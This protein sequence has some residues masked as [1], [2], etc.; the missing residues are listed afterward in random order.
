[1]PSMA[2]LVGGETGAK[3]MAHYVRS[4]S[5]LQHDA[6][7]AGRAKP[8]FAT[9]AACHGPEARGNPALGAPNLTDDV[10]LHGSSEAAIVHTILKGRASV[11]PAHREFLG[12]QRAHIL[13]AYVYGLS[14]PANPG[15][16]QVRSPR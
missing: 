9:C 8:Q 3:D 1:M 13:A 6:A 2:A 5:G 15:F 14:Q 16:M 7:A 4:L 10:W 12:E 11:M